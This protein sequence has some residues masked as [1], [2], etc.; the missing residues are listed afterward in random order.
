MPQMKDEI[1]DCGEEY[2]NFDK[3]NGWNDTTELDFF[4]KNK[5][6]KQ[7]DKKLVAQAN[8]A[9]TLSSVLFK[10]GIVWEVIDNQTGWTHKA[11]C[12]FPD[13]KD[14]SPSFGYN[15]KDDRFHCFGCNRS[16]NAVQFLA[17]IDYR[18]VLDVAKEILCRFHAP[19]EL[20]VEFDQQHEKIDELL[21]QFS[22]DVRIFLNIN[23]QN[24][25]SLSYAKSVM[26]CLD[27]YLEKHV[28][29][30]LICFESLSARIE[31]LR[32]RLSLFGKSM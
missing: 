17:A 2:D 16:G 29:D 27:I 15:S 30:G 22:K 21:L 32:E 20:V 3:P 24:P 5:N 10:R 14:D 28:T 12:P 6:D 8:R 7:L 13:H 19:E 9:I 4:V 11:C 25:K 23:L 31:K 26:W 18:N 1:A